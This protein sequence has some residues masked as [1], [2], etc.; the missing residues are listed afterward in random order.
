[1]P[2][3]HIILFDVNTG[4]ETYLD[5]PAVVTTANA[6]GLEAVPL[7]AGLSSAPSMADLESWLHTES[8]LGGQKIEGVVFKNYAQFGPDKKALM[9]KHVS[10]A[11]K[12]VHQGEWRK[13]NPT[14]GDIFDTLVHQYRTPAR[15]AKAIQHL[16]ESGMLDTSPKDIG[17]LLKEINADVL[18]EEADAIKDALFKYAWP[19]ISRGITA[20]FPEWYKNT[21][22]EKQLG[23]IEPVEEM[24]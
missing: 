11:F 9:G 3:G 8:V 19:R 15:W 16:D 4:E 6:L 2:E 1:V 17:P 23:S 7:V 18:K 10:E 20:G 13:A 22:A 24:V 12:E 21:L 14:S 5:Y